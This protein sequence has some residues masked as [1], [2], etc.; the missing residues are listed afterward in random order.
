MKI[1]EVSVRYAKT[2]QVKRYEPVRIELEATATVDAGE[3]A[4]DVIEH[5]HGNLRAQAHEL[6]TV[7]IQEGY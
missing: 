4:Q 2:V 1:K 7:D 5:L 3:N 6:I